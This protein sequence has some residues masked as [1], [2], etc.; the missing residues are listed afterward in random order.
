MLEKIFERNGF[1][2]I[3]VLTS[4][5]LDEN[6]DMNRLS[7]S[8]PENGVS[9]VN[10]ISMEQIVKESCFHISKYLKEYLDTI[11]CAKKERIVSYATSDAPEYSLNSYMEILSYNKILNDAKK[12]NRILFQKLGI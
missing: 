11:A 8:I 6:V 12:R 7:L 3:G 9:L 5:Y 2:Y 1:W 4:K 10:A